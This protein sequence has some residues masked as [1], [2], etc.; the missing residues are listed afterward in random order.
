MNLFSLVL[1]SSLWGIEY[2]M[3][4]CSPVYVSHPPFWLL[5]LV[6]SWELW[7]KERVYHHVKIP[8]KLVLKLILKSR[9][10]LTWRAGR[11]WGRVGPL[12]P[13]FPVLRHLQA[14]KQ[15]RFVY[16]SSICQLKNEI[17]MKRRK[18]RH[19]Q[20]GCIGN[21]KQWL[22]RPGI[23]LCVWIWM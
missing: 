9:G 3:F 14:A 11:M 21:R 12:Y 17:R 8:N 18:R 1:L 13:W 22:S 6:S 19:I 20:C 10:M 15:G 16:L 2:K 7:T 5:S 23:S 4:L